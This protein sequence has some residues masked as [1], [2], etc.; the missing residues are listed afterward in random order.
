MAKFQRITSYVLLTVSLIGLWFTLGMYF[1]ISKTH[2]YILQNSKYTT[3]FSNFTLQKI[4][5]VTSNTAERLPNAEIIIPTVRDH[6][7]LSVTDNVTITTKTTDQ[8][9]DVD[10]NNNSMVGA[11][12]TR[13]MTLVTLYAE[14]QVGAAMN[15]FSL[16]KWAKAVDISVV[17]PFVQNSMFRL[18]IVSSEKELA[19]KLRFRDYFDIDIWNNKSIL[20]NGSALIPWETF[21][22]Q[23]PKKYIFVAILND[24]EDAERPVYIGDE[25]MEQESCKN[26]FGFLMENYKFYIDQ[27]L[28][29]KLVRRVCFCFYKTIMHIDNFT[30]IIYG[31]FSSSD[32]IV[33]FQIW[34]GFA[35]HARVRVLQQQFFRSKQTFTMLRTSKKILND[36]QNYIRTIL[37]SQPGKYTAISI[38]TVVR[39]KYL[40]RS[41]HISFFHDCIMKLGGVINSTGLNDGTIFMTIDLGRFGDSIAKR[42][43]YKNVSDN[44]ATELFKTIYNSSLTQQK[45]E[46]SFIQASG[47]ITDSGYIAAM[48]RTIVENGQCL[49]LFGGRSNFQ[50]TLLSAYKE[51]HKNTCIY[52][53]CYKE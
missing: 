39:A 19:N 28:H 30:N 38:R 14:Q 44:I 49:V 16:Q 9:G 34:K 23:A 31:D 32:V 43:M 11:T 5:H 53:V 20:M 24:F 45:W 10:L 48:Q 27:L 8:H 42:F 36:S 51:M 3:I 26:S 1:D 13:G 35:H 21:I 47:G 41:D 33:W 50:R 12:A 25:I 46:Q 29:V 18:P 2:Y 4:L 22:D 52:K 37:K 17:E 15:L 7:S 40:P 6:L